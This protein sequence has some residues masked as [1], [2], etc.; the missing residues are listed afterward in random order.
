MRIK[1]GDMVL[2]IAGKDS[3][4][5][6]VVISCNSVKKT[7]TIKGLNII[8][9]HKKKTSEQ[10]GER[11][12][13]ESPISVSNVMIIDS[14]KNPS[15]VKYSFDKKGKKQRLFVTTG[16]KVSENFTKL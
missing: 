4:K 15:R 11:I 13:K 14:D 16:K 7:V 2:V 6:G 12:E 8:V 10:A 9:K 1:I 5:N 3:G